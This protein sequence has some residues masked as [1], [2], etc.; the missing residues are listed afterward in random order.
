MISYISGATVYNLFD[1]G[2]ANVLCL[3]TLR[4]G[5]NHINNIS[6]RIFGGDPLLGGQATGSTKYFSEQ[7]V[8]SNYFFLF[9]D[10]KFDHSKYTNDESIYNEPNLISKIRFFIL[11]NPN[12]IKRILPRF[13][14]TLSGYN[15]ASKFVE[16]VGINPF[17]ANHTNFQKLIYL[18]GSAASLITSPTICFRFAK[19]DPDRFENDPDYIGAAYRTK[20]RVEPWRIGVI[21][22][23]I[24]GV[25]SNWFS[26]AKE[27]PRKLATGIIQI[28]CGIII[29]QTLSS[30]GFLESPSFGLAG[31]LLT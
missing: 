28:L 5:T 10:T 21:G 2:I 11:K 30:S 23:L 19:I 27:N 15:S 8:T 20:Q 17:L 18:L 25:N 29:L 24:E 3:E 14:A 16:I 12:T 31:A 9:K 13:H 22:S 1:S 7:Y 6:I 26:R 4:H